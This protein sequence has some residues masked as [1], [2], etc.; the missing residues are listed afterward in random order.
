MH[1]HNFVFTGG[2]DHALLVLKSTN[3]NVNQCRLRIRPSG[4]LGSLLSRTIPESKFPSFFWGTCLQ[5]PLGGHGI[6][7][8]VTVPRTPSCSPPQYI[9]VHVLHVSSL[10]TIVLRDAHA[11]YMHTHTRATHHAHKLKMQ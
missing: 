3:I 11:Y 2:H 1:V 10:F 9:Y 4:N 5:T 7:I 6:P 8:Q